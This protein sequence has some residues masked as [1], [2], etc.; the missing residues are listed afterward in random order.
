[1][2][3]S[4]KIHLIVWS[5]LL[6]VLISAVMIYYLGDSYQQFYALAEK[7][8]AIPGLETKFVPQGLEYVTN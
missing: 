2:K 3:K 1:M 6:L 5:S 4:I 7:D 8:F